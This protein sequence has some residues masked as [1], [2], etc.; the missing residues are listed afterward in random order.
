VAKGLDVKR[1]WDL[2]RHPAPAGDE[3]IPAIGDAS[4]I[5]WGLGKSL[6]DT[7]DFTD[8]SGRGFQ[9]KLVAGLANS[10]FQGGLLIDE[11]EFVKRF[12]GEGG[13][14]FFLVDAPPQTAPAVSV[15]LTRG[16]QDA[17]LEVVST[18][19]RLNTFNAVQNTYLDTFQLLGGL[20]LVLGCAGLGVVVARNVLE[21]RGELGLMT[22]VGFAPR[23]L[24]RLVV[25]EHAVLLA[26]G[27]LV[28]GG[29]AGL[30]VF[31]SLLAPGSHGSWLLPGLLALAVLANGLACA[32]LAARYALR[33]R[34]LAALRGE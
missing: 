21:R 30:A 24:V 25:G 14:R 34:L 1:G 6:G 17:G 5:E 8:E 10:I 26:W 19:A 9:V 18:A 22:A 7:L 2:L 27:L 20:G 16:L 3:P 23:V 11:S 15:A 31:P 4:A 29:A 13:W 28:G 32:W 33:G 12:P